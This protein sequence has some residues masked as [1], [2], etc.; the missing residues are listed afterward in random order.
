M[1]AELLRSSRVSNIIRL[2]PIEL[3]NL[4]FP[5]FIF[6]VIIAETGSMVSHFYTETI[7]SVIASGTLCFP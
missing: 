6:N 4:S 2:L 1:P 3:H 5:T 7:N